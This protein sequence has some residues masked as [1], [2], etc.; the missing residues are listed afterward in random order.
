M[1]IF[2]RESRL[3]VT[4]FRATVGAPCKAAPV[5]RSKICL[6]ARSS[7]SSAHWRHQFHGTASAVLSNTYLIT[8]VCSAAR[9]NL[10]RTCPKLH[11]ELEAK[12]SLC[13][14]RLETF[15]GEV[16]TAVRMFFRGRSLVNF[17]RSLLHR[18]PAQKTFGRVYQSKWGGAPASALARRT[19]RAPVH[20]V[21]SEAGSTFINKKMP[22]NMFTGCVRYR[23][24]S[25]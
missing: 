13:V 9:A 20:S 22:P 18:A 5:S 19:G 12:A 1:L 14:I 15:S 2:Q 3:H 7:R 21:P 25:I 10:A 6:I 16:S 4:P 23:N 17:G 24:M 8:N 11:A